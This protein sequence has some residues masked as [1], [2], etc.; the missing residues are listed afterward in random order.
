LNW[1]FHYDNASPS[2]L[3]GFL[4]RNDVAVL[5]TH[6]PSPLLSSVSSIEG[7]TDTIGTMEAEP[8]SVMRTL[9]ERG[10]Q[11]AFEDDRSAR[12]GVYARKRTTSKV[13]VSSGRKVIS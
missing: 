1:L 8:H 3:R 9:T 6:P 4:P 5:S 12:N 7:K 2:P 13:M 10:F 11:D